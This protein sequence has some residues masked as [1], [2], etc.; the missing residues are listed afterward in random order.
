MQKW[1]DQ[2]QNALKTKTPINHNIYIENLPAMELAVRGVLPSPA[3]NGDDV[4]CDWGEVKTEDDERRGSI[5]CPGAG[6]GKWV[7]EPR[8][9]EFIPTAFTDIA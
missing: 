9:F 4:F 6:D 2:K 3:Q 8:S 5:A 1:P 7:P